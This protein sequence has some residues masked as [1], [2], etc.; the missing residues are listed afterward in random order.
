MIDYPPVT[1]IHGVEWDAVEL[2]S[3]FL[4]KLV[5]VA[6]STESAGRTL[7]NQ[8]LPEELYQRMLAAKAFS[9]LESS[10]R[11]NWNSRCSTSATPRLRPARGGRVP[12]S[13]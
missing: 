7:P 4:E 8:P 10:W 13:A 11:G 12:G 3:Q 6:R 9:R 5:L 1:G 2:P